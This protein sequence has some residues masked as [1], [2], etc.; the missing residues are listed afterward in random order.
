MKTEEKQKVEV[1]GCV[2]PETVSLQAKSIDESRRRFAKSGVI[3][4]GVL[5]TLASR[6]SLGG[7]GGFGGGG[8]C[9]SPSG[10]L[11]GN[12]SG[13]S[14]DQHCGGRTP[15]YWANHGDNWPS[16]YKSGS[17]TDTQHK[18]DVKSWSNTGST[19]GSMFKNS[20]NCSG[21]GSIYKN[22]SLM[23]VLLLGGTGDPHQLGAHIVAALLNA[24]KGWT[25]VLTEAQVK[26]IFNEYDS[27]GYF[28]PTAGVKWYPE[29]IV[30]YL[31][32]TMPL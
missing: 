22:Y 26:N 16:P 27:H 8:V 30:D 32:T 12:A 9:K 23:Q 11:S 20:F 28:E 21:Y 18:Q 2:L 17:C 25:P 10:F 24:C 31:K 14:N 13:H 1:G 29:D 15:G 4:S 7:G 3:V 6:P 19:S 5:L